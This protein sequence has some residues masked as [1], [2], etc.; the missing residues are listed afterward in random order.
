MIVDD[1]NSVDMAGNVSGQTTIEHVQLRRQHRAGVLQTDAAVTIVA[2][3]W[4]QGG[5]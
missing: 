3:V 5:T 2:V 4:P 1:N